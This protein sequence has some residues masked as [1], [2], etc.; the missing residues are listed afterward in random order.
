MEDI[1]N[2]IEAIL[3]TTG[4]LMDTEEIS[5]LCGIGSIGILK[6]ALQELIKD[7]QIRNTA[8]EILEENG[9]YKLNIKKSYNYLTTKL[10]DNSELDR[11]AQETLAI[12][13][14][15]QPVLQSDI[16][17]IRGTGAYDHIKILREQEFII[18]EK[19][20]RSRM[21]KVAQ[22]FYEYFDIVED[23]MK[24]KFTEIETKVGKVEEIQGTLK[25]HEENKTKESKGP[26][27]KEE[28]KEEQE[29]EEAVEEDIEKEAQSPEEEL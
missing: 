21:L 19:H 11:P 24:S 14:Y 16:I 10:L 1:K 26:K 9:R 18:S 23:Q 22:K 20:G 15:K 25:G 2:R 6:E 28:F 3:F 17:K 8:L 29:V 12:I 27:N 13:A 5:R 7:Y 4:R